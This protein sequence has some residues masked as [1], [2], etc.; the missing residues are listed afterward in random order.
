MTRHERI[1]DAARLTGTLVTLAAGEAVLARAGG[2]LPPLV[3]DAGRLSRTLEEADPLLVAMCALRL[4]AL[5]VGAGLLA[6]T[7][8]GIV[9]RTLGSARLVTRLD[10]L[11][12]PSL[13]RILDGA[14]GAGLAAS[15]GLSCVPAGAE[16]R[17]S[18]TVT[19]GPDVA[20]T[21]RRLADAPSPKPDHATTAVLR[22]LPD[23]ASGPAEPATTAPPAPDSAT[24]PGAGPSSPAPRQ[25]AGG[26]EVVV[27]P[28]DSFWRLAEQ[29]EVERLGRHP[30]DAEVTVC[31]KQLVAVNRHRLVVPGDPDLIFPGQILHLPCP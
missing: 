11:T 17:P 24:S 8:A 20:T 19:V 27:R 26:R 22:R 23:G 3:T 13:R 29:H 21:L 31:S 5:V 7:A 30:S 25:P 4:I 14:L 1:V 10:R 16:Q 6:V 15:I 28:G 12:P 2:T 9:A 18:P